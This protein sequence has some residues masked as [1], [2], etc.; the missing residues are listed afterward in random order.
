M[1]DEF[2]IGYE[3]TMPDRMAVRVRAAAGA[4]IVLAA[5]VPAV[6]LFAQ[7]RS[8]AAT[9]EFGRTRT[10]VGTVVEYPYP[11]LLVRDA[12]HNSPAV[13]WLV[14]AGKRGASEIVN[15]HD[16][17]MV[18]VSGT[19]IER[20]EDRM[21]E[22]AS[23]EALADIGPHAPTA[24]E[25]M[26]SLGSVVVRGEIVD[27]K[28]HLGVMKPGEGPTHRDCAVR[29]LLGRIT[30]MFVPRAG[31]ASMGRLALVDPDGRPFTGPLDT[32]V[33]RPV[34]IHGELF[35]RGPLRFLA[36]RSID[37]DTGLLAFTAGL[38]T[39][40]YENGA[41]FLNVASTQR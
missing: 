31:A 39:R 16:G 7:R 26:R 34:E 1:D 29:C 13:Y 5:V 33:G 36:A 25:S 41:S 18:R 12:T 4:L 2:Y 28:C 11:A 21:I 37:G 32:H 38:K 35:A 23:K 14:G 3:P 30:P 24:I 8:A 17:R 22:V 15:G 6:L 27:S 10:F 9:F 19:L 40:L 20:D